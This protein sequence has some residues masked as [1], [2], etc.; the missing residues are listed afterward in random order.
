MKIKN[1]NKNEDNYINKNQFV[2]NKFK[3]VKYTGQQSVEIPQP[4]LKVI[5]KWIKLNNSDYLLYK[6]NGKPF[7]S[8]EF[9]KRLNKIYGEKVGADVLRSISFQK[10]KKTID[11]LKVLQDKATQMGT[12]VNAAQKYYVKNEDK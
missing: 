5:R 11:A 3:T 7:A 8:G 2:F 6:K 1:V 4:L 9:S 10:D 12:S